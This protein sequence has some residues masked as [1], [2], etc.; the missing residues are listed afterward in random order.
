[1]PNAPALSSLQSSST[2]T[3][4][5]SPLSSRRGSDGTHVPRQTQEKSSRRSKT[6]NVNKKEHRSP[7]EDIT[8]TESWYYSNWDDTNCWQGDSNSVCSSQN[9]MY[10]DVDHDDFDDEL[11]LEPLE[12]PKKRKSLCSVLQAEEESPFENSLR[13]LN[14]SERNPL[15]MSLSERQDDSEEFSDL[16]LSFL[17]SYEE[18][19]VHLRRE[20]HR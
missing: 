1:M 7:T 18:P 20:H 16:V 9:S 10:V 12:K 17:S 11:E 8:D 3:V 13:S 19:E 14:I 4:R 2:S 5:T 6:A 15:D